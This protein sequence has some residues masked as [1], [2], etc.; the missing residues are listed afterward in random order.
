[1][2]TLTGLDA[3]VPT[4]RDLDAAL[5]RAAQRPEPTQ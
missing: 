2:I 5:G 4:F 1:M 3:T